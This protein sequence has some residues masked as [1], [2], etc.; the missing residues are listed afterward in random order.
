M[1][2]CDL[3]GREV[4]DYYEAIIEGSLLNVCV[5]C[6]KF[7]KIVNVKKLGEGEKKEKFR[8]SEQLKKNLRERFIDNIVSDYN[9]R[10]KGAREGMG[11]KQ[12]EL[13]KSISVK[14]SV[15]HNIESKR[16]EPSDDIAKK[17]ENFLNIVLIEKIENKEPEKNIDLKFDGLTIGDLLK[18]KKE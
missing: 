11:L 13:A 3:C 4:M 12:E 5:Y 10:V 2:N 9:L 17:L 14:E 15:I 8:L 1:V 6:S 18:L 16:L 7:G